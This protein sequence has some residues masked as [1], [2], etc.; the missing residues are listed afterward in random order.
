MLFRSLLETSSDENR[1]EVLVGDRYHYV[2]KVPKSISRF[3]E[4]FPEIESFN[5]NLGE[6]SANEK[7][8]FF[9]SNFSNT[10]ERINQLHQSGIQKC[11]IHE[12]ENYLLKENQNETL[13]EIKLEQSSSGEG[14]P[15][16]YYTF[17][18]TMMYA[19]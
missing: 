13:K 7:T 18:F 2:L 1:I 16:I 5:R 12:L 10:H 3:Q 15:L 14:T 6:V 4:S 9:L 19:F 11:E 8:K 17:L